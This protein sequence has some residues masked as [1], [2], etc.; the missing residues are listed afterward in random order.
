MR[1]L[2]WNI[3]HGGGRQR[4]PH[5]LMAMLDLRPDL[6]VVT[7]ARRRFA[8][9]LAAAL[10]DAGLTH[11]LHTDPPDNINGVLLVANAPLRRIDR[12]DLPQCL[13]YRWL[14]ADLPEHGLTLA[15]V[16]LAE[17]ARQD[18]HTLGWRALLR[19]ARE[20]RDERFLIA[21]DLNTWRE[22]SGSRSGA[23][24][25]NLGRLTGLGY[26]DAWAS[27]HP[28]NRGPT[29]SDHTGR[30]YRLDYVVLS[31][32]LAGSLKASEIAHESRTPGLSDH[33]ALVVDLNETAPIEPPAEPES[34][35]K[36]GK[37]AR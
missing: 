20:Q 35:A 37:N 2:T 23:A 10:A 13:R 26:V 7:E 9:Q 32:A 33:A 29:W 1:I 28:D 30:G 17:A 31:R 22:P 4:L 19:A 3:L 12:P 36:R 21:G 34:P 16:H 8:G 27:Q 18:H 6:I 5:L 25:T 15:G 24:A 14:Q 11:S